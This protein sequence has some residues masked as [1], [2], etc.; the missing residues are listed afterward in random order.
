MNDAASVD[1]WKRAVVH[2]E[3]A[4]DSVPSFVERDRDRMRRMERW[5]NPFLRTWDRIRFWRGWMRFPP[6]RYLARRRNSKAFWKRVH[7][8]KHL[9]VRFFATA[10]F[11]RHEGLPYLVTARHVLWDE[12]LAK[13]ELEQRLKQNQL[14][15]KAFPN[16]WPAG[17]LEEEAQR[18]HK[19]SLDHVVGRV[20]R[21]P[22]LGEL[23]AL[24]AD[25]KLSH[26]G[27]V[28]MAMSAGP[29]GS[30]TFSPPVKDLAV[31]SLDNQPFA[32]RW[33]EVLEDSG[34]AAISSTDF[35]DEPSAD[36]V[37]VMTIGFPGATAIVGDRGLTPSEQHWSSSAVCLPTL[38][39][40][41]VAM[42]HSH[43]DYFWCDMSSYPGN[44]G[45]PVVEDDRLV[46]IVS[47][48]A[49]L[50]DDEQ[51][52]VPFAKV[53]KAKHILPLLDEQLRKDRASPLLHLRAVD[54]QHR[55]RSDSSGSEAS[56]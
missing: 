54:R 13:L 21:V 50:P 37:D 51:V 2:I 27:D 24:P 25:Q 11:V 7:S 49:T 35:A 33:A 28:L 36:G 55:M 53:I 6:L 16:N 3:C 23:L 15:A 17:R 14:M 38:A 48:Q 9:D 32:F 12:T 56:S 40:G 20:L 44:S 42:R 31:L 19:S 45:A 5:L 41:K 1:R 30:V 47:A 34:Y 8:E 4:T 18:A 39:F 46:G 22:T 29:M 26:H 10:L 43:L 52:R